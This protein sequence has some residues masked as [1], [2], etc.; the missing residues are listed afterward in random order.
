MTLR[1]RDIKRRGVAIECRIN[2]EDGQ[3]GFRPCP[4]DIDTFKAPGGFGVRW[5][6]HVGAGSVI[7]PC[8]DS[9]IGKLV[10][11]KHS[12]EEAIACMSRC[13]GE[14]EIG[15]LKTTIPFHR[16]VFANA[17]FRRGDVDTHFIE[18]H[19]AT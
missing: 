9:M 7:S 2:A 8:Y 5:D 3:N 1:Q 15:P 6:S 17:D 11:H 16:D 18:R 12:R 19:F 13:L 4:G 14:F 10:V